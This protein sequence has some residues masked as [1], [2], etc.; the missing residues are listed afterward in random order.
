MTDPKR[1]RRTGS[2]AAAA[3]RRAEGPPP[4]P[5]T[6]SRAKPV[7]MTIEVPP[8]L[9]RELT[10]WNREQMIALDLTR[11]TVSDAIRAMIRVTIDDGDTGAKV[12]QAIAEQG[13]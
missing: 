12:R 11:V 2:M 9:H 10:A 6:A 1:A 5:V 7:R 4:A 13:A 8:E 3:G